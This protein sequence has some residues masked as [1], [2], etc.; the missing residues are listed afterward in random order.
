[1]TTYYPAHSLPL[2]PHKWK[3]LPADVGLVFTLETGDVARGLRVAGIVRGAS[4]LEEAWNTAIESDP[5]LNNKPVIVTRIGGNS[6][7]RQIANIVQA[8]SPPPEVSIEPLP[9]PHPDV[10]AEPIPGPLD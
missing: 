2:E 7:L 3:V 10:P 4:S 6:S 5:S 8:P 1:M 9:D